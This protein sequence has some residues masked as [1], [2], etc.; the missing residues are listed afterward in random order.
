MS[1]S[2]TLQEAI[3]LTGREVYDYLDRQAQV[4]IVTTAACQGDVSFLRVTTARA[5]KPIP[6]AGV[7]VATGQGGHDHSIHGGGMF[8][9]APE[10]DG[11]LII[12]TLT[13]PDGVDVLV[14]HQEHGALLMAPGTYRVGRQREQ[15]DEIRMVAD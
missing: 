3:D 1:R 7:V 2:I 5:T 10:R 14:S 15:A 6:P 9:F 11:S 13:V 8:D 4:P 12:G